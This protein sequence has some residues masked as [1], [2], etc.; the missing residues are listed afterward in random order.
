[1]P[2]SIHP[3]GGRYEWFG[4]VHPDL[5]QPSDIPTWLIQPEREAPARRTD[6]TGSLDDVERIRQ[7]LSRRDP[8]DYHHWTEAMASVKHWEDVTEGA[9]GI[10]FELI[11]EWSAL[12]AK[13]DDGA[14]ADKWES[15]DSVKPG[16]RALAAV[17]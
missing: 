5:T 14:L 8:D 6:M 11:R 17:L 7:A 10:G 12:S 13:H 2:P 9:Q 1:L 3:N 16:A 15:G 4:D